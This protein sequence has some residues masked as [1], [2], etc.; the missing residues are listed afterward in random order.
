[1]NPIEK[2]IKSVLK[3]MSLEKLMYNHYFYS[4]LKDKINENDKILELGAGKNSYIRTLYKKISITAIDIHMPSIIDAKKRNVYN[5]YIYGNVLDLKEFVDESSF[6]VVI[7]FDLIEH[8]TKKDGELLVELMDY[9]A[10]K[11]VIIYTP[12]GFLPQTSFDNNSFQEHKSGWEYTEMQNKG[13]KVYG[14]N[15]LKKLSGE[16]A[17]PLI[18]PRELGVFIRNISWLFLKVLRLEKYSFSILCIKDK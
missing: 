14:I 5:S 11:T 1:M 8:F 15:G 13:F 7:S 3:I 2:K 4:I 12:N 10:K 18:K 17:K 16:Y 6:D 9:A